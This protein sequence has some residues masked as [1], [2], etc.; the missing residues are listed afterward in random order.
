MLISL[1]TYVQFYSLHASTVNL[2]KQ[3]QVVRQRKNANLQ[4]Q[5]FSKKSKYLCLY[6]TCCQR[7]KDLFCKIS[8]RSITYELVL[9]VSINI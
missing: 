1:M 4:K 8:A 9:S 2:K 6:V 5:V 7:G 3:I